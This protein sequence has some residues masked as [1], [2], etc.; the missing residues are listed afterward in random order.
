MATKKT[1]ICFGMTLY[2]N[3]K[4]LPEAIESLLNQSYGDFCLVAVDDCS[5]DD[6]EQIM[7]K[8]EAEDERITYY[9]NSERLGMIDTWRLAFQ[10]SF[11]M[12]NPEYFAWASDHDRWHK[13][14]LFHHVKELDKRQNISL[15]YPHSVK[16]SA[17]GETISTGQP[18]LFETYGMNKVD[19]IYHSCTKLSAAGYAVYGLFRAEHL[20]KAGVFRRVVLPDRLLIIEISAYGTVRKI[21][22]ELWYR[23]FWNSSGSEQG[24]LDAQRETLD[25][26]VIAE[27]RR[28][29]LDETSDRQRQTLFG[30][31]PAP[32]HAYCPFISHALSLLLH[33]SVF[34]ASGDYGTF[35]SGLMTASL[36]WEKY[37]E[38]FIEDELKKLRVML[39][40]ESTEERQLDP[41]VVPVELDDDLFHNVKFAKEIGVLADSLLGRA[42]S[43]QDHFFSELKDVIILC[44]LMK[45]DSAR[46]NF[47]RDMEGLKSQLGSLQRTNEK[48]NTTNEKLN[49]ENERLRQRI[50]IRMLNK[51]KE[52]LRR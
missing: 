22:E 1:R 39:A 4:Y 13:D 28:V 17:D 43:T 34:P 38:M 33:L 11:E 31:R 36:L 16:I 25:K 45:N 40:G 46:N 7:R 42:A 2:N 10:K 20:R 18:K 12:C 14:W 32:L 27:Q 5:S 24:A 15:V 51:V 23:R 41:Q 19:R 37:R 9:R 3:V 44:T 6:T 35:W 21:P 50:T 29:L 30:S 26:Q 48:L 49:A 47:R 8:Y 52:R